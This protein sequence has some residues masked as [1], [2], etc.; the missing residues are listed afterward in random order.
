MKLNFKGSEEIPQPC[1][2]D[3]DIAEVPRSTRSS[4]SGRDS[5]THS[6]STTFDIYSIKIQ[7]LNNFN[8]QI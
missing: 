6:D 5:F 2:P 8:K 1:I 3:T 7:Y 4:K